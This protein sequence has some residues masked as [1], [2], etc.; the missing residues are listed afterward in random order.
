MNNATYQ[1]VGM[2]TDGK[3]YQVLSFE[4]ASLGSSFARWLVSNDYIPSQ[5]LFEQWLYIYYRLRLVEYF[6]SMGTFVFHKYQQYNKDVNI[7]DWF[8]DEQGGGIED[9]DWFTVGSQY[10]ETLAAALISGLKGE[11]FTVAPEAFQWLATYKKDDQ[12]V[13]G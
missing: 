7:N 6:S 1:A 5:A 13:M 11:G 12:N 3:I 4:F 10:A 9:I 2:T 8:T